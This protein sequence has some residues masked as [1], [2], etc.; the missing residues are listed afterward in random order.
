M[1]ASYRIWHASPRLL[2]NPIE[3][4]CEMASSLTTFLGR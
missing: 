2:R 4:F 3:I 1:Y